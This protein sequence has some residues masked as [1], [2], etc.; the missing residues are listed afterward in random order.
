MTNTQNL[1]ALRDVLQDRVKQMLNKKKPLI[2]TTYQSILDEAN[3][4]DDYIVPSKTMRFKVDG[5]QCLVNYNEQSVPLTPFINT[6]DF[7]FQ[8]IAA[9]NE[10]PVQYLRKLRDG[11]K[12][13]QD[14]AEYTLNDHSFNKP[15]KMLLRVHNNLVKGYLSTKYKRFHSALLYE[16]FKYASTFCCG[17]IIDGCKTDSRVF[18]ES[19]KPQIIEINTEKS[20]MIYVVPGMRLQN[21]EYGNGTLELKTYLLN[22]VC[23]NGLVVE[24]AFKKVHLGRNIGNDMYTNETIIAETKA[25]VLKMRDIIQGSYQEENIRKHI[26]KIKDAAE[27]EINV[28]E[29]VQKLPKLGVGKEDCENIMAILMQGNIEDGVAGPAT[30]WKMVNSITAHARNIGNE[31]GRE[32][33]I[34]AGNLL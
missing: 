4:I 19:L 3:G 18:I 24:S 17:D 6:T 27:C 10:I 23:M 7:A 28:V 9:K 11:E 14:L 21:S 25:K 5:K 26:F 33:E 15:G 12:W 32:L 30:K 2:E 16:I 31:K 22:P 34:I 20:G 1:E 8:Q 29:E 13:Q